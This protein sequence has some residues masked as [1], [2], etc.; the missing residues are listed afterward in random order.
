LLGQSFAAVAAECRHCGHVEPLKSGIA[1]PS[2]GAETRTV[3]DVS[4]L[5]LGAAVRSGI[6]IVHVPP[7][8]EF[9][10][11]GNVAALLR[12]RADQN[13]NLAQQAG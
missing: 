9:E 7:D 6:E 13:T 5:M 4:D 2:C 1:C 12:F 11:V 10:K 8:P 3:A